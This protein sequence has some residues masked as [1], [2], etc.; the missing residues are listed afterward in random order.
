MGVQD[1]FLV[2]ITKRVFDN[3]TIINKSFKRYNDAIAYLLTYDGIDSNTI[4]TI[5]VIQGKTNEI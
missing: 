5:I 2:K 3:I 1:M 4:I